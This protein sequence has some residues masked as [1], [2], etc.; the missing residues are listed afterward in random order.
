MR[1]TGDIMCMVRQGLLLGLEGRREGLLRVEVWRCF[2]RELG[3]FGLVVG[4]LVMRRVLE[5]VLPTTAYV[6]CLLR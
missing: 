3:V 4:E 2:G 5:L 1:K 6:L